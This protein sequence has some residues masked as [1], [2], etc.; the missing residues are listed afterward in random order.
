MPPAPFGVSAEADEARCFH[1]E[2][3]HYVEDLPFWRAAAGRLGGPVLD[4]G[5]ATGRVALAL[6]RDGHEVWA[7]D[8]SSHMLAEL[9]RRLAREP[10]AVAARVL[11]VAGDL[12]TLALGRRFPLVLIPM[13]TLQALTTPA[14]QLACLAGVRRHL[15][16]GG[17]LAFDVALPDPDEITGSMGQERPGGRHRDPESGLT[18][19][20]SAWYERWDPRTG[21]LWFTL[22]VRERA[23]GGGGRDVRRRH[24]VHLF[25]PR[26]LSDLVARASLEPLAVLGDFSGRPVAPGCERQ[27]YRC[28]TRASGPPR[29]PAP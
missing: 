19:A 28:R 4:L 11:P 6:A 22:R 18:L 5:A 17:E 8:R 3:A 26:E 1:R 20:H 12:R 9:R 23:P 15:A 27:I 25:S 21:T 24:R 14:D 13:N 10:E 16:P 7:L 2:H 29:T